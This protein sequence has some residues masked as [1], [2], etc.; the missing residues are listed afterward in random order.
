MMKK[1][2]YLLCLPLLLSV[3]ASCS[4][5]EDKL[6]GK[7]QLRQYELPDG[8]VQK[9][10]SVFYNFQKGSFSAICLLED[11]TYHT[12]F[13][14]YSLQDDKIY[15]ILRPEENID[16]CK[17]YLQWDELGRTFQI[18][19]LSSSTLQLRFEDIV[20]VFRKY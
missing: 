16:L 11:K 1:W 17:Q 18:E 4:D 12:F 14:L 9:E 19:E 13:G 15:I 8:T 5:D 3:V 6:T 2:L 20:S 7:W 10:D